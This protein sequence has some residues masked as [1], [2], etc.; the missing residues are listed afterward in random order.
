MIFRELLPSPA[1]QPYVRN[2]LLVNLFYDQQA[3][4]KPPYPTRLEQAL[5]FFSRGY[6]TS[7]NPLT[8]RTEPIAHNALF[9]QQVSRL[10]F[11]CI[12]QADFLMIMVVFQPGALY[13]LLGV[14]NSELTGMFCDAESILSS[15]LQT[16]N[17]QVANAR[18]Y[19]EMIQRVEQYLRGKFK[20]IRLDAHPIDRIGKLLLYA[21]T[22]F[23]LDRLASQANLSPR[24]FE[25]KFSER[26]GIGPKLFSRISRF[27]QTLRY[28]ELHSDRD[29]L[30]VAIEFGYNDYNHLAKDFKQFA[31]VTPNLMLKE[32]AQRPEFIVN[33]QI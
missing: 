29:W 12:V 13:R 23:Q 1:L 2:Y 31:N 28:K 6:I 10:D 3:F 25:R 20:K 27:F 4:P 5:V 16:V 9:G 15:E 26:V 32:Y 17:D 11:Q 30:T 18:S 8:G 19:P 22:R 14:P 21:P 7:H 33:V 24:Q